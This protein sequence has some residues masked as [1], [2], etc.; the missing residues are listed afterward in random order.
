MENT[1]TYQRVLFFQIQILKSV[2]NAKLIVCA[3]AGSCY[4]FF[5]SIK[6]VHILMYVLDLNSEKKT[7]KHLCVGFQSLCIVT[8]SHAFVLH[9]LFFF[10][11]YLKPSQPIFCNSAECI[12]IL[13]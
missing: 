10:L 1:S 5:I 7:L 13:V 3:F 9:V 2:K 11:C 6:Y 12:V 8:M 4:M